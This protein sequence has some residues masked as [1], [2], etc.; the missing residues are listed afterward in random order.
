ML[1]L[2]RDKVRDLI[3]SGRLIASNV[4]VGGAKAKWLVSA[5]DL[6]SFLNLSKNVKPSTPIRRPRKPTARSA[7]EYY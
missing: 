5:V 1:G 4:N 3:A 6:Q 2:S 7:I